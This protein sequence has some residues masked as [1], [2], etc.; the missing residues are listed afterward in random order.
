M[1]FFY[2]IFVQFMQFP[3]LDFGLDHFTS[4]PFNLYVCKM[5]LVQ[6]PDSSAVGVFPSQEV[7]LLQ[8]NF[9]TWTSESTVAMTTVC[10]NHCLHLIAVNQLVY[11]RAPEMYVSNIPCTLSR[12]KSRVLISEIT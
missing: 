6:R 12:F 4:Q 7:L 5:G 1:H 8:E 3:I 9:P 2:C 11:I 10:H